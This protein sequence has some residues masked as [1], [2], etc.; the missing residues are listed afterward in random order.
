MSAVETLIEL[1]TLDE[2]LDGDVS[3]SA[4]T[5]R[6]ASPHG[7]HE[8]DETSADAISTTDSSPGDETGTE[9]MEAQTLK[10]LP[11]SVDANTS[12]DAK[13]QTPTNKPASRAKLSMSTKPPLSKP[14]GSPLVKKV[15]V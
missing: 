10:V 3:D 1:P 9:N 4:D 2:A 15:R 8:A 13:R 14:N 5:S 12:V 6:G 7:I 11:I